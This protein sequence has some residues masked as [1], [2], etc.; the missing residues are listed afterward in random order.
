MSYNNSV[1]FVKVK[2]S[3]VAS[4]FDCSVRCV[5]GCRNQVLVACYCER[6]SPL[7]LC[8]S[9]HTVLSSPL[10][11]L[12][13]HVPRDQKKSVSHTKKASEQLYQLR[14]KSDDLVSSPK[15]SSSKYL[16]RLSSSNLEDGDDDYD[17]GKSP[18]LNGSMEDKGEEEEE[19]PKTIFD[20]IKMKNRKLLLDDLQHMP[21]DENGNDRKS[22]GSRITAKPRR[23][24]GGAGREQDAT[25]DFNQSLTSLRS[26]RSTSPA[27]NESFTTR[28][29]QQVTVL[30]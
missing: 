21:V 13:Q 19:E 17:L 4:V 18:N 20:S 9:C 7:L 5:H 22:S 1:R 3:N 25:T 12:L 30:F 16:E 8:A 26:S 27:S 14:R 10:L 2:P 29:L 11:S 6:C 28:L 23:S 15:S 24:R